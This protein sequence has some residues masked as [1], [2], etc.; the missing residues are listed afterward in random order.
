MVHVPAA[1]LRDRYDA[2]GSAARA[3]RLAGQI[4]ASRLGETLREMDKAQVIDGYHGRAALP[5]RRYKSRTVQQI[6][7]ATA[8]LQRQDQLLPQNANQ[9]PFGRPAALHDPQRRSDGNIGVPSDEIGV[10]SGEIGVPSDE[11]GVR[12]GKVRVIPGENNVVET[13]RIVGQ[14]AQDLGRVVVNSCA[15]V[16]LLA[17]QELGADSHAPAATRTR[18]TH[19]AI[20]PS[21]ALLRPRLDGHFCLW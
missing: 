4:T 9:R 19:D 12:S 2:A 5:D 18:G 11:I 8:G 20:I 7:L 13:G 6:E 10:R 14:V 17:G 21:G 15:A 1:R 3:A 16:A